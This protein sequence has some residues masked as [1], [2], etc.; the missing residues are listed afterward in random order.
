M[1]NHEW[2]KECGSAIL[3]TELSSAINIGFW[4]RKVTISFFRYM[5]KKESR[6]SPKVREL[7]KEARIHPERAL[8]TLE[9]INQLFSENQ[10]KH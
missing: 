8:R 1:V 5:S 3:T 6:L 9:S 4:L 2:C 10:S 7:L